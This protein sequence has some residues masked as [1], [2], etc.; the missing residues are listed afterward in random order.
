MATLPTPEE[1]ARLILDY[2]G[3]KSLRPGE[4]INRMHLMLLFNNKGGF[5]SS[6]YQPAEDLALANG[7]LE[8]SKSSSKFVILTQA[9]FDAV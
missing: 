9:G 6:D 4:I 3:S 8:P 1:G 2:A 5:R 7:W